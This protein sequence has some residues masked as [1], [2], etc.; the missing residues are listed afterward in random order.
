MRICLLT[1]LV[2]FCTVLS[3]QNRVN[4]FYSLMMVSNVEKKSEIITFEKTDDGV[5]ETVEYKRNLRLRDN[6]W[7]SYWGKTGVQADSLGAVNYERDTVLI[8]QEFNGERPYEPFSLIITR[9]ETMVVG[10]GSV[11]SL[12]DANG[13]PFYYDSFHPI[14]LNPIMKWDMVRLRDII[15]NYGSKPGDISGPIWITITRIIISNH[16]KL[17]TSEIHLDGMSFMNLRRTNTILR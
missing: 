2:F 1:G 12:D 15:S 8:F 9:E 10:Y 17:E 6:Y 3:A 4:T 7:K 16:K 11:K 5:I 14:L 13:W